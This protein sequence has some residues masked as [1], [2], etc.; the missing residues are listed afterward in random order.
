MISNKMQKPILKAIIC[1]T[2]IVCKSLVYVLPS[3]HLGEKIAYALCLLYFACRAKALHLA[4]CVLLR[5]ANHQAE[6]R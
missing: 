3:A 5:V 4:P 6:A 1:H 2:L